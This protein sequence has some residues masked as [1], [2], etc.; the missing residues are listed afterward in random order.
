MLLRKNSCGAGSVNSPKRP[1]CHISPLQAQLTVQKKRLIQTIDG[2]AF[3]KSRRL[4]GIPTIESIGGKGVGEV[5]SGSVFTKRRRLQGIPITRILPLTEEEELEAGCTMT[6][7]DI[8]LHIEGM[9]VESGADT[10]ESIERFE[11]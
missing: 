5:E 1:Y 10:S 8:P 3:T 4:Q 2:S 9:N 11:L 7:S 6:V